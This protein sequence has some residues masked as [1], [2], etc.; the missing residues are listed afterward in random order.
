[1]NAELEKLVQGCDLA[2]GFE[3]RTSEEAMDEVDRE[4][5]VRIRVFER[6]IGEGRVSKTDAKDRLQ[7]LIKA[8][9][10]LEQALTA[11]NHKP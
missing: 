5:G 7:R 2:K 1:M 9:V 3:K 10:L 4:L 11:L 6:W 8:S